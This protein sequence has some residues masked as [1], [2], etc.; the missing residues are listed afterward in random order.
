MSES[1]NL[2]R[3]LDKLNTVKYAPM[4]VERLDADLPP[5]P[6]QSSD[7]TPELA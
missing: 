4:L 6:S 7:F 1:I 5:I 3:S 2:T